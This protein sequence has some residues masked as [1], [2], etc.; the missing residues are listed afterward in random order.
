MNKQM[1][2]DLESVVHSI[3]G[4]ESDKAVSSFKSYLKE[5]VKSILEK[6]TNKKS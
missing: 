3:I 2:K 4:E 1:K 5:K 6:P